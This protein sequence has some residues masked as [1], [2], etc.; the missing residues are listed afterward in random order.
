LKG[1]LYNGYNSSIV[2]D[3]SDI[4][5]KSGIHNNNNNNNNRNSCLILQN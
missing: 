5:I 1:K 3:S 4:L 2:L